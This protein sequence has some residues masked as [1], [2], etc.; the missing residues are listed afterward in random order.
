MLKCFRGG[1]DLIT[2][3]N[4]TITH[5]YLDPSLFSLYL[6]FLSLIFSHRF[7]RHRRSYSLATL[8]TMFRIKRRFLIFPKIGSKE[9]RKKRKKLRKKI[10]KKK[11]TVCIPQWRTW[12]IIINRSEDNIHNWL[13]NFIRFTGLMNLIWLHLLYIVSWKVRYANVFIE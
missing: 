3:H 8:S 4:K 7:K 11:F 6:G 13:I 12:S 9:A 10:K 1:D 2:K 5:H